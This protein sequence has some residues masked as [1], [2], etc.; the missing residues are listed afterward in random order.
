MNVGAM[1][2]QL[3]SSQFIRVHKSYIVSK[4]HITAIRKNSVFIGDFEI[5]V[6]FTYRDALFAI[7]GRQDI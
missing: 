2:E 7:T 3:P 1:D 5:P 6:S 4:E